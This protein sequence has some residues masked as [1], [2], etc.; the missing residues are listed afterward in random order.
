VFTLG[1]PLG[2]A[3]VLLGLLALV[4]AT[5]GERQV[6]AA[7]EQEPL[8][9]D[10]GP[11]AMGALRELGPEV[12]FFTAGRRPLRAMGDIAAPGV[13]V[14]TADLALARP[15]MA[16]LRAA[17]VRL[18]GGAFDIARLVTPNH[19]P[20]LFARNPR[21]RLLVVRRSPELEALGARAGARRVVFRSPDGQGTLAG[22]P[23][24]AT[25]QNASAGPAAAAG[26]GTAG[27]S[28]GPVASAAFRGTARHRVFEPA[29]VQVETRRPGAGRHF[30]VV[31]IRRDFSA[32]YGRLAYLFGSGIVVEPDF[33]TLVL[34]DG[35]GRRFR[36]QAVYDLGPTLELGYVVPQN[37]RGFRL[38][39]GETRIELEVKAPSPP[40][41]S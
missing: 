11:G 38:E 19:F 31:E 9:L 17:G 39:D 34:V 21:L 4:L 10:L 8:V 40:A 18:D 14:A 1:F 35:G 24:A 36:P 32:G 13:E 7:A 5:G 26:K 23:V 37:A 25:S 15:L 22:G 20:T 3:H 28:F 6:L 12:V 16:F 33:S 27:T 41:P 30:V 2:R 29:D